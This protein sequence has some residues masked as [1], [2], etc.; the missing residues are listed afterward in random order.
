MGGLMGFSVGGGLDSSPSQSQST[1]YL[2]FNWVSCHA[3][4]SL[5]FKPALK[6][7]NSEVRILCLLGEGDEMARPLH[8]RMTKKPHGRISTAVPK[9]LSTTYSPKPPRPVLLRLTRGTGPLATSPRTSAHHFVPSSG[10]S[11]LRPFASQLSS[12]PLAVLVQLS[13]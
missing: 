8:W 7:W 5:L 13:L 9:Q 3:I 1:T 4:V 2:S 12:T 11:S 6:G 10:G